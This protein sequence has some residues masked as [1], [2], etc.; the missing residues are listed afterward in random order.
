VRSGNPTLKNNTFNKYNGLAKGNRMM[1]IEGTV[2][3]TF[4]LF[5]LLCVSAGY[6]WNQYFTGNNTNH[7]III[8][9]IAG[10]LFALITTFFPKISPITAPLYAL[11]EGLLIGGLS[12]MFEAI[13]KGITIQATLLTFGTLFILLIIY[14][15]RLIKVTKNFR[16]GVMAATGAI[17]LVYLVNLILSFFGMNVPYLHDNGIIGIGISLFIVVIASLN[18]VLDFDFIESASNQGVPKYMEW[19]GAFGLMVTLVWLYIEILHLLAKLRS[20]N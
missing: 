17:F 16:L 14:R 15:L 10:L 6:V 13:Y 20:R 12:A 19:Y 8:G 1:T 11:F 4:L 7:F 3:K 9:V 5:I 18:L 2:N